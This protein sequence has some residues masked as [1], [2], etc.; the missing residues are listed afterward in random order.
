MR[1]FKPSGSAEVEIAFTYKEFDLI[2]KADVRIDSDDGDIDFLDYEISLD[3]GLAEQNPFDN[4]ARLVI[5]MLADGRHLQE[6]IF[7]LR[8]EDNEYL[9]NEIDE[10][11][12]V[13]FKDEFESYVAAECDYLQGLREDRRVSA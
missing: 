13:K 6:K 9:L 1:K 3:Y 2:L 10:A 4:V 5:S 11:A 12:N 7:S 8:I